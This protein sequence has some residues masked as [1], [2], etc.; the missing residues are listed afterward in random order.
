MSRSILYF[1]F[2]FLSCLAYGLFG[3]YG[4]GSDCAA[5]AHMTYVHALTTVLA[6]LTR[7]LRS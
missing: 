3:P 4:P 6:T 2:L 5:H 7:L 1:L